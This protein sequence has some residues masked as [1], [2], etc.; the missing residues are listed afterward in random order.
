MN[1]IDVALICKALG[2]TN[3]L[4]IV[5]MLVDGEKCACKLLE[6]FEITQ[7]T[8][9]HHMKILCECGLVDMRKEGKWSYYSFNCDTLA[10]F[11]HFI[12]NLSCAKENGGRCE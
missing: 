5:Q 10:A 2:D 9:S 1:T 12:D 3:R 6:Q 11:K 7:P 8:L 4:Q